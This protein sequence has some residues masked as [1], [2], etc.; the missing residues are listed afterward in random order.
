MNL[1]SLFR[2]DRVFRLR[3]PD[4]GA[5]LTQLARRAATDLGLAVPHIAGPIAAREKLGST[6][7]G[8]GIAVPHA[9]I[10][11]I[12]AL[13][14]FLARLDR[15]VDWDA[16]DRRPVDLVFLLLSPSQADADH[17]AALSAVARRL[18]EPA[19]AAA[20]RAAADPAALFAALTG[21]T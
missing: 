8:A 16:I 17:L 12:I 20:L 13:Q 11:G 3:A 2:P 1:A 5:V 7:V 9:R 14:A 10:A 18:R 21:R 15:A 19:A 4:K 6:G